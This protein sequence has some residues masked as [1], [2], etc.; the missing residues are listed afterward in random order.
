MVHE[1]A[2]KRT[3][4]ENDE[5]GNLNEKNLSKK[6]FVPKKHTFIWRPVPTI[7]STTLCFL[8]SGLVFLAIGAILLY[9][10]QQIK[11]VVVRYDNL[12]DCDLSSKNLSH[13][14]NITIP[15]E[16][17]F[18]PPIMV[19]YQLENFYQDHRR[20]IKSKSLGQ[21]RGEDL[22]L[23]D[24]SS[25]C[26][27]IT[28][29]K[30]LGFYKSIGN[31]SLA[32]TDIAN[33]CGL[34]AKSL[35]NDTFKLYNMEEKELIINE[36]NIAWDS[37]K[38]GRFKRHPNAS[39]VQWTDVEN[40]HFMVWMRPA[41]LPDFRK[42]WGRINEKLEPG[43]YNLL[44]NNNFPVESFNGKKSFVLS[45]VNILGGKNNFL[46]IAYLI[47]GFIC[48]IMA[49]LFWVGYNNYNSDKKK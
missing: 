11:E 4:P 33:P 38:K 8:L 3:S 42:L 44:I 34:I 18:D 7:L 36:T 26:D 27:P 1:L 49:L 28:T 9:L 14:C 13:V 5:N 29:I 17:N 23:S 19:Y 25:D 47:V 39:Y 41:G 6:K 43:K 2:T 10:S 12:K 20:Y 30:D 24:I 16:E 45:T 15:I 37:D 40:E 48:L 21:L 46:G 31:F 22:K 35:F 32:P